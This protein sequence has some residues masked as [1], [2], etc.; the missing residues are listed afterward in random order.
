MRIFLSLTRTT[1]LALVVLMTVAGCSAEARKNRHLGRADK[2]FEAGEYEKAKIE[3]LNVIRSDPK[4]TKAFQRMAAIWLSQG[5]PM[6]AGAFLVRTRELAPK[7][8]EN[9]VNLARVYVSMNALMEARKEA[10]AVLEEAPANGEALLI[11]AEA[12]RNEEDLAALDQALQKFPDRNVVAYPSRD[13][14]SCAEEK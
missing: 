1:S 13:C 6:R 7:D 9:R 5:A 8:L 14:D 4:N 3:Y 2:Y 11:L 12:A 10:L